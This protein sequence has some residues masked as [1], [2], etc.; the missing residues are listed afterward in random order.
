[1]NYFLRNTLFLM[2]TLQLC[3]GMRRCNLTLGF[4]GSKNGGALEIDLWR[5]VVM[6]YSLSVQICIKY[7]SENF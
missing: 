6:V 7:I 3:C 1:M 5:N 4:K 2:N